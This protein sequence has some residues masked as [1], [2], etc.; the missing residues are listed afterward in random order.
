LTKLEEAGCRPVGKNG[1]WTAFCPGHHDGRRR[2]LS[3]REAPDG[4][5]L[6]HCFH[7]RPTEEILTA[8]GLSWG[9]L[10]PP[11]ERRN[12]SDRHQQQQGKRPQVQ[13]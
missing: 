3:I 12:G 9:D 8:L 1:T 13:E 10:F 5:V 2:G 4:R 7:G 6:L 11:E